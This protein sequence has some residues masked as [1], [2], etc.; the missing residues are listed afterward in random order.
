[1]ADSAPCAFHD[2]S[3]IVFVGLAVYGGWL[4]ERRRQREMQLT[5]SART[6]TPWKQIILYVW[7]TLA[8]TYT[9]EFGLRWQSGCV[10]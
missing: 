5:P 10:A 4:M 2:L 1:M 3:S 7:F 6:P 8:A 9:V